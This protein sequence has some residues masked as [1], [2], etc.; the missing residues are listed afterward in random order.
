MSNLP[1]R[2]HLGKVDRFLCRG[3]AGGVCQ[4]DRQCVPGSSDAAGAGALLDLAV[5]ALDWIG[6]V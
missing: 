6:A 5:E 1:A 3:V 2:C 4:R